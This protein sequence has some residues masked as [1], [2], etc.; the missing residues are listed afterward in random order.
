M[1]TFENK[2]T[3][4]IVGDRNVYML[5]QIERYT[6]KGWRLIA[7]TAIKNGEWYVYY[8]ERP[9]FVTHNATWRIKP[10]HNERE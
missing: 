10:Q 6:R 2:I 1:H 8:F 7:A 3:N 4:W 5:K 9:I